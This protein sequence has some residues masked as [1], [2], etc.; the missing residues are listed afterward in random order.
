MLWKIVIFA[1]IAG[2]A[3][4]IFGR[5]ARREEREIRR[6]SNPPDSPLDKAKEKVRAARAQDMS[7]C[8]RC[9]AYVSDPDTCDCRGKSDAT[10]TDLQQ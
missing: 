1:V 9:G 2:G 5:G 4:A 3:L 7:P 10:P 6:E 8:P